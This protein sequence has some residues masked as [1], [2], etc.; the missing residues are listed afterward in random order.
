M[1]KDLVENIHYYLVEHFSTSDDPLSPSGVKDSGLLES[2]CARPR[3]T[4]H[5]VDIFASDYEKGAALLHGIISNH[6][7]HNGNKRTALLSVL[8]YLGELN[9]WVDRCDDD[10]LYD[11]IRR[12][13]AHEISASRED[14]IAIIAGWLERHSRRILKTD[15]RL[16]FL[17]LR[18]ALGRFGFDLVERN[19]FVEIYK[20][21]IFQERILKKGK[22]GQE[23]YDQVYVSDLRKR[24]CLTVD[25]GVDSGR[26]YGQKGVSEDL[27]GYMTIRGD[28]FRRLADA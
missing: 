7:F 21:G 19:N 20:E 23:E 28:V 1:N 27:N 25:H 12:I 22:H 3:M 18:E 11:F 9:I 15:K 26:F 2:A 16:S 6:C 24:L 17:A 14:E 13:A 10:V 4:A 5:G 8:Y